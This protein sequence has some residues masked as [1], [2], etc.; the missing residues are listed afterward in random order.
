MSTSGPTP[1]AISVL[2]PV[3][4]EERGIRQSVD[5]MRAQEVDDEF[6]LLF[7]DGRSVDT[8]RAIL[9]ELSEGDP[10]IR[11]LDN[12]AGGIPQALNVGLR[13]ARGK[14]VARMDAHTLYP[15]RYLA[16]GV[17]RLRV[18]DVDWV[19]GPALAR[20]RSGGS[21]R[22]ALALG[23]RLG[24]GGA[25]FRRVQTREI[26]TDAGFTGLW[27]RRTLLAHGG[28]DESWAVNEDGELAARIRSGGGRIVCL[29]E[30]AAA[31]EPRATVG[32]L[33]RQ[34][35]RY[36][37][38]R[39]KTSRRHPESMRRS[40]LIPPAAL[41]T[42]LG[43]FLPGRL[44]IPCRIGA[45][46]YAAALLVAGASAVRRAQPPTDAVRVPVLLAAMHLSWAAGFVVG[47]A[48]FGP[49]LAAIANLVRGVR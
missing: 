14:Y 2:V 40:H 5:A 43:A 6:E 48:R 17:E 26:E 16:H 32:Q 20:G 30:M 24:V 12:P 41:A 10:R 34:Y 4:D 44:G 15:T 19:A 39:A 46:L 42:C 28:W 23:S 49:P 21:R 9:E 11:I 18:G 35:G 37:R 3:R 45:G 38:Y 1:P 31:Y 47:S 25:S 36:G 27:E 22:V 33:V 8:T 29:P 7:I 13:A